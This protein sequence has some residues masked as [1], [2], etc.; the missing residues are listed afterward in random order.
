MASHRIFGIW[1][2]STAMNVPGVYFGVSPRRLLSVSDQGDVK[3]FVVHCSTSW[4]ITLDDASVAK[5]ER[6]IMTQ[7][8]MLGGQSSEWEGV[9][10]RASDA[11]VIPVT[12]EKG[13]VILSGMAVSIE[14]N[15]TETLSR[16]RE[17]T[18]HGTQNI[19]T[20]AERRAIRNR[21]ETKGTPC[22]GKL[23]VLSFPASRAHHV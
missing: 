3:A 1:V 19:L 6:R 14:A 4:S 9:K 17:G 5:A 20:G 16:S 10:Q 13:Y 18:G 22:N 8:S 15:K 11:L 7:R 12:Y 21:T 23:S 2:Q